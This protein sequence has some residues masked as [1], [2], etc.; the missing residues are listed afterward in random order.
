MTTPVL[1]L[2]NLTVVY[3]DS[4]GEAM[5]VRDLSLSLASGE[6]YGLV[7]ESGCGKTTVAY[8]IVRHLADNGRVSA[9]RIFLGEEDVLALDA[10]A[11]R[12]LRGAGVAMVYQDPASALNPVL[13]IGRQ[14]VEA[15]RAHRS[16][17]KASAEAE[18]VAMLSRVRLPRPQ[19][20]LQRNKHELS[21]GQLQRVVIAMALLARP[22]LL[23]LDEPT[24]GLDATIEAEVADLIAELAKGFGMSMIYISHNLR[25]IARVC[26]RVGV[27]YAGALVEEGTAR[28]ILAEPKHP[29]T[30]GLVQCLPSLLGPIG[31]KRLPSIPG[32][33]PVPH[34]MPPGCAF[35]PRCRF[36]VARRCDTVPGPSL[37]SVGP[38]RRVSCLRH[39]EIAS[40][41]APA[42]AEAA[43]ARVEGGVRLAIDGLTKDYGGG[44][45]LAGFGRARPS[46][47][48]NDGISLSVRVGEILGLVGESGSGKTTLGRIVIGLEQATAGRVDL[49]GVDIA[50]L[51]VRRR[52]AELIRAIQMVFQNPDSTL[53]PA[54]RVGWIISRAIRR[55]GGAAD[56][57]SMAARVDRLLELV[58]LPNEI[59]G[60]FP[61]ELS[62][63][64]RQRVAI[65]RAFAADPELVIADEPVSALDVSVQAAIVNLLV[66]VQEGQGA[67][68]VFI[69]HDLALVR[70]VADRVAVLF[71][72][73]VVETGLASQVFRP[74][75]HPYTEMLLSVDDPARRRSPPPAWEEGK[76]DGQG[77]PFAARCPRRVGPICDTDAPAL[78]AV[79]SG[80]MISC[81][82]PPSE[83]LRE[84][85]GSGPMHPSEGA[86]HA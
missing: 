7:G 71:K 45:G 15:V 10:D 28:Q 34:A 58:R 73:R 84:Q 49:N 53:N 82:V 69:S 13:T 24:T 43:P 70:H 81:H 22:R 26:D 75:W 55:L 21:G 80:H 20:L 64:Q 78:R 8:A 41:A 74:P 11:L 42:E 60:R 5:A 36:A 76:A 38:G 57:R 14:L 86:D 23:I 16:L 65:A 4:D 3:G 39:S 72:G 59:V 62:G 37:E 27:M 56:R 83:L 47:R 79:E 44:R 9:G 40:L 1:R 63:G 46:L 30:A 17:S 67:T 54:H 68:V 19:A 61:H 48:A 52:P 85:S 50:R 6:S 2:Q 32:Q 29:Y 25:L 51:M 18:V 33:P 77:C 66:D 31:S 35:A 12:R